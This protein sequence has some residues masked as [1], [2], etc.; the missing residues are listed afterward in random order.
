MYPIVKLVNSFFVV[1]TMLLVYLFSGQIMSLC[2]IYL[3]KM[4]EC[5]PIVNAL[6][7]SAFDIIFLG[8]ITSYNT[9]LHAL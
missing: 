3:F 1:Q 9:H 7:G 5:I 8:I 2:C 4:F 6:L